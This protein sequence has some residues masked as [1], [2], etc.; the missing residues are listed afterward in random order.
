MAG[1]G[2]GGRL[3]IA[4]KSNTE[5]RVLLKNDSFSNTNNIKLQLHERLR[6]LLHGVVFMANSNC[7]TCEGKFTDEMPSLSHSE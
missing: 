7:G 3:M 2:G 1:A 5:L 6:K 4:H